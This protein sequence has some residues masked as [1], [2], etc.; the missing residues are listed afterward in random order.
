V[1]TTFRVA[2][3]IILLLEDSCCC[4]KD[5]IIIIVVQ[6]ARLKFTVSRLSDDYFKLRTPVYSLNHV[7][8]VS[9]IIFSTL[10]PKEL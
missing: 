10:R 5:H 4:V 9:C 7:S 6:K 3:R 8:R 2:R 1:R